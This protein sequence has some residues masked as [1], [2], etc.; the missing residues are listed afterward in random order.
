MS[1]KHFLDGFI[2][3]GKAELK[4]F[5]SSASPPPPPVPASTKPPPIP[6]SSK[7][8]LPASTTSSAV[9]LY[10][11]LVFD[12]SVPVTEHFKQELGAH[13]WGNN[14]SQNYTSD[15]RNCFHTADGKLVIRAIADSSS[16]QDKYTSARLVSHQKLSRQRGCLTAVL[17][18]PCALGIW[19]AFWLLPAEPFSWPTDGEV[20]IFE[21]WNGDCMNRSCLHWGHYNGEDWNKHR[22]RETS[23]LN[24]PHQPHVYAFAW[25]QPENG[26]GGR[27][28]W[29]IDGA[30]VMRAEIPPGTRRME[31]WRIIM[32][33]AMGGNV[34]GGSLPRD[35]C[36]DLVVSEIRMCGEPM[37]GWDGFDRDWSRT[38]EGSPM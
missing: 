7:P 8:P 5:S 2:E 25:N 11:Q 22:T 31:D 23:L 10:W 35:G 9:S 19:P 32:N 30:P 1:F 21:S 12:P 24:M 29:Y 16:P 28:M 6:Q 38:Q 27:M 4:D 34:C 13:G 33:V 17:Q 14:E 15:P 26:I 36:Y 18:P 20:D 37:G 3:R